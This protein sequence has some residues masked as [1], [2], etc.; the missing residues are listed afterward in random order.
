MSTAYRRNPA[1]E[2]APLQGES[3][4]FNPASNQFCLL[5]GTAA[6][7]WERLVKPATV[8]EISAEI[9]RQFAAPEPA[10]VR[11]DVRAALEKFAELELVAADAIA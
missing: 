10:Q 7:V 6:F 2:A 3:I 4:L 11:E 9:C 5:N 8:E 1:I